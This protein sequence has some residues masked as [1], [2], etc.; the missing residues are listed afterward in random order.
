MMR[1]WAGLVLAVGCA[2][3]DPE[4]SFLSPGSTEAG[5]A[6]QIPRTVGVVLVYEGTL[7]VGG[8]SAVDGVRWTLLLNGTTAT[9]IDHENCEWPA[10]LIGDGAYVLEETPARCVT[11]LP[12]EASPGLPEEGAD[13]EWALLSGE[14]QLVDQA[15][16]GVLS[17][18]GASLG[19]DP[20]LGGVL[21]LVFDGERG[22]R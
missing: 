4:E 18:E 22:V 8:D 12:G 20:P 14:V 11:H 2:T 17:L 21:D 1:R 13:F 16:R 6:L 15:I 7:S 19:T 10:R 9:L 3:S 5:I